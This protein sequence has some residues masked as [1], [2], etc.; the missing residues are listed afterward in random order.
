MGLIRRCPVCRKQGY[1]YSSQGLECK[2]KEAVWAI[3]FLVGGKQIFKTLGRNKREAERHLMKIKADLSLGGSYQEIKPI[4]FKELAEKWMN[5]HRKSGKPK[6]G[7]IWAYEVRLKHH[8]LPL[9]GHQVVNQITAYDIEIVKQKLREKLGARSTNQVIVEIGTILKYGWTLN[10]CKSN[11]AQL[12]KRY[13]VGDDVS[14]TISIEEATTL[15]KHSTEPYRTIFFAMLCTGARVGEITALQWKDIDFKSDLIA[16]N[17]NVFRGPVGKYGMGDKT[18]IFGTPKSKR[19]TRKVFLIPALKAALLV[20]REKSSENP[21]DLVFSTKSGKPFDRSTLRDRLNYFTKAASL[22]HVRLHD[23]RH[24]NAT[25][26]LANGINLAYV[27]KHLGHSGVAITGDT[28]HHVQPKE[29][30][31]GMKLLD[32]SFPI[33]DAAEIQSLPAPDGTKPK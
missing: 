24:T 17:R 10:F 32:G 30:E 5:S 19:S 11:P 4:L 21:L 31:R 33:W 2:H 8:I 14:T 1:R 28:Y 29:H 26:L 25:W 12:V 22:K 27:S 9:M 3:K 6:P 18:W 23:L 13:E 16:I 7:T 15:L 20:H